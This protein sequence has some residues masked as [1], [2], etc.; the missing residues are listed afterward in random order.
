MLLNSFTWLTARAARLTPLLVLLAAT[1]SVPVQAQE[2]RALVTGRIVDSSGASIAG[3]QVS[4][5]NTATQTRTAAVSGSDGDFALTQLAPG[6]YELSVEA[7]GFRAYIRKGITLAV[8]DKAN[9][10]IKMEIGD[11]K[12]SVEVTADLVGIEA[13]QDITGQLINNK[14]VTELPLNGRNVFM[15]VQLSAG[16]VFTVTNFAPGGT[17]GTR[18]YDL[19]GQFSVHGSFP[20]TS[21]FLL[22]GVPIQANGQS[23]YVPLVDGVE[24]FKITTP[25]SDATQGL[26]SGGVVNMTTKS[27]ANDVHG[28][29]SYFIRNQIFDAVRTQEKYTAAANPTLAHFQHQFNDASGVVTGPVIKNKLFFLGSYEGFWDRVPRAITQTVPTLLQRQGNFSQTFNAAGQQVVIYD[30]LTTT[31]SGNNFVRAA[32]P[33]NRIPANRIAPVSNNILGFIPNPNVS[34]LPLTGFNN[35]GSA[36]NVGRFAYNSWFMK[37]NYDWNQ[38]NRTFFSEAQSYG[39]NNSSNN[40]LPTGNPAKLGSDPARRNH[41][42]ATLDH[43][44]TANP[45]TVF[46][47][48]VAWDRFAPYL[49]ETSADNSDGSQLGFQGPTGSFPV[50]RFPSLTFTNY[51][52]LG[53][54]GNNNLP[55][56]TYTIVGDVSKQWNRHLMK[57]GTRLSQTRST[58]INTGLWYGSFAFSPIWTQRNPQQADATSGNDFASFL[59]GYP[60]SGFTDSNAQA[61]V[62]NK[63]A[64]F[65][66]QDDIKLNSKLTVNLGL[67]WDIQTAPTERYDRNVYTFDPTAT[68]ALGPSQAKGQLIFADSNHRQP[69]DTKFRDFQPRTGIAWQISSKLV[70]R[71]GYGLTYM[72]LNGGATCALCLPGGNGTVDQTGYSVQTPFVPTLGGGVSSYI[73]GLAGTGTLARPFPNGILLP[74]LPNVPYARAVSFQDR[75]YEIPR[76]HLF[77]VGFAYNLPWKSL[78][79]VAYVG[80]RTHKYPVSKQIS[81]IS[82][83]DRQLGIANPSYLNAAVPN[84]YFGAPQ[85]A[86]TSLNS[87]S[88]TRAQ[89]LSPFPQFSTVTENGIP[90][91]SASYDALELRL[92]KRLSSGVLLNTSYSFAKTMESV[93]YLEPQYTVLEHVLTDFDRTHHLTVSALFELPF[94]RGRRFGANWG[95]ALNLIAGNWQYNVIYDYMNGTPTPMPNAIPLRD[96][97]LPSGQQTYNKWFDTCTQ[98]TNGTRTGCSSASAPT[99]WQ[100][101][102]PNQFRVASTYFPNIRNDWKPNFNMSVFKQFPVNER[103]KAEFRAES[104]NVTNSPIYAAPN[105]TVTSPLFGVVTISQQNFPRNMQFALR[106]LF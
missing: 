33:G 9:L 100:Q 10:D 11:V 104:F 55:W 77:H 85:L 81:A 95:K 4:I 13:N 54:T 69:W 39:S 75:D 92:H 25:T 65:Y 28:T 26:T 17:S 19:F 60:T 30:P 43:V 41:Y 93:A 79:D 73:P 91:G 78:L 53:N 27:G 94:G 40:G 24:E 29:A 45:T 87:A 18:A 32:F 63:L 72:P 21:A 36:P 96:P 1:A 37:F 83:A 68:Y 80:T 46:D 2:F 67:R 70:L 102:A 90:L 3:A 71:A 52:P 8:G 99:T 98:L 16:V 5:V 22:D 12:S 35:L 88:I 62:E 82:T 58:V 59:L 20:N 84:P 51:M 101:L 86:G 76:V 14:S 89:A 57:F 64:S 42:G 44:Y 105:N 49:T 103:I 106:I 7:P 34:T 74:S 56:D 15:L 31:Q 48:R 50:P 38:N 61:S 6:E 97:T 47:V 23:S 66:F